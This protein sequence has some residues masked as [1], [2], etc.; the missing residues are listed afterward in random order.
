MTIYDIAKEAGVSASTVSRVIN[1][2]PGI[3]PSTRRRVQKLLD[4]KGFTLNESARG[5]S[6]QSSRFIGILIEDIRVPH[7]TESAYVIEQE[8]TR[9]GYTCI[10]FSTG[11]DPEQ[12]AKYIKILEQ[13]RVE[14]AIMIGSMFGSSP[15]EEAVRR[16]L[17]E[18]PIAL[19]NGS[20]NLPNVYSVLVDE[21]R[22]VEEAV[23]CLTRQRRHCPAFLMDVETPSNLN[24]LNGFRR[25]LSQ[26]G[27]EAFNEHVI[28]APGND[29]SPAASLERGI[30]AADMLLDTYPDTDSVICA[31]DLLAI[32]FMRRLLE[33]GIEI[34][35]QI[36]V[37]GVDNSL[38]GRLSIPAL[39]TIDNKLSEV[40]LNAARQ[41][42]GALDGQTVSRQL[43][44]LPELIERQS[45]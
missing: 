43:L 25:G 34:P 45:T 33:R 38:Y 1:G 27:L 18:V 22:G 35:Q 17:P 29:L 5:L 20:L 16:C 24:K 23:I 39:S 10:T 4:E 26:S 21:A 14:G 19:A 3:K 7:H 37:I 32:G 8:M 15:V 6:R 36:A 11:N 44:L 28:A 42:L 12:K 31:T 2:K 9:C 40:S 30:Q 13:H 41:L